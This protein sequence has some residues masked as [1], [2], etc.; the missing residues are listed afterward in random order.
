MSYLSEAIQTYY[1]HERAQIR[2]QNKWSLNQLAMA[3]WEM[4]EFQQIDASVL[5][6]VLKGE[7]LFTPRQLEVFCALLEISKTEHEHLLACLR[8]DHNTRAGLPSTTIEVAPDFALKLAQELTQHASAD[9]YHGNFD[10]LENNYALVQGLLVSPSASANLETAAIG[11]VVGYNLYLVGRSHSHTTLPSRVLGETF[12]IF[13]QLVQMS[14]LY[15]SSKLHGYAYALLCDA[16]Y[17]AGGYSTT[18]AKSPLYNRSIKAAKTAVDSLP[19][20][21]VEALFALRVMAASAAY[22]RDEP[23]LQFVHGK[24]KQLVPMQTSA[25]GLNA[26]HLGATLSRG[27]AATGMSDHLSAKEFIGNYFDKKS[28]DTGVYEVS[29]V[30][31]EIEALQLLGSGDREYIAARIKDGAGLAAKYKLR[32]HSRYFDKLLKR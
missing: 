1:T 20:D 28:I 12:P 11:D 4:L 29:L 30:K 25:G 27:M 22:L 15:Q 32:R 7:R 16:Y 19:S 8:M 21:S 5:S 23:T 24:T 14:K 6:R 9:Y 31:E 3:M 17:I 18:S 2:F 13:R 10:G 26:L